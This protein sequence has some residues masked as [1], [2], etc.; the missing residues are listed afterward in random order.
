MLH[1]F[2]TTSAPSTTSKGGGSNTLIWIVIGAG[3][4][5]V[6]YKYIIKPELDKNKDQ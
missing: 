6:G 4:L 1:S 2:D 3:L 5:Y